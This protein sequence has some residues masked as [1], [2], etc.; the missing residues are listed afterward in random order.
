MVLE[1]N[2]LEVLLI[3]WEDPCIGTG[4]WIHEEEV[5]HLLQQSAVVTSVGIKIYEDDQFVA[6]VQSIGTDSV[7]ELIKI[8]KKSEISRAVIGTIDNHHSFIAR[9]ADKDLHHQQMVQDFSN[10]FQP[11][12]FDSI[13]DGDNKVT[14]EKNNFETKE[15]L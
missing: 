1:V 8:T 15:E 11:I 5:K 7:T 12:T 3:L 9:L 13:K 10:M 14:E 6:I 4:S 2:R